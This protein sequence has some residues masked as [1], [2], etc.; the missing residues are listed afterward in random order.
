MKTALS[1]G[2]HLPS[3]SAAIIFNVTFLVFNAKFLVFDTQFLVFD[4]KLI[5]FYLRR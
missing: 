5:I 4:T 3:S 2:T 1:Q